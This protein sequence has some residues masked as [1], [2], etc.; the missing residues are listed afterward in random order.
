MNKHTRKMFRVSALAVCFLFLGCGLHGK[1]K[2]DRSK[3]LALRTASITAPAHD[4][5]E[6]SRVVAPG[7]VESWGGNIELSPHESGWIASSHRRSGRVMFC[8]MSV[9]HG[10]CGLRSGVWSLRG[11][12]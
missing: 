8:L 5:E 1:P 11:G 10:R 3:A 12:A 2:I 9:R 4:I 7:I 6:P